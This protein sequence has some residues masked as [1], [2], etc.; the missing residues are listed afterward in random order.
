ML[1]KL[2]PEMPVNSALDPVPSA[3]PETVLEPAILVVV[4][5][6]RLYFLISVEV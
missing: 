5:V 4:R 1:S 3:V 2:M 6:A